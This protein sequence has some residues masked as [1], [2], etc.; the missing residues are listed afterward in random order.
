MCAIYWSLVW[1]PYWPA[2]L[3]AACWD[4][5]WDGARLSPSAPTLF[6]LLPKAPVLPLRPRTGLRQMS[7]AAQSPLPR[8][9]ADVLPLHRS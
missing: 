7:S 1:S 6:K 4:T 8:R 9:E 2:L 5:A 3:W